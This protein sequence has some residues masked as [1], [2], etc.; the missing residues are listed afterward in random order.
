MKN[1][2]DA[3]MVT[4]NYQYCNV[5]TLDRFQRKNTDGEVY[6]LFFG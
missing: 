3:E 6:L 1:I 2:T 5:L 4:D